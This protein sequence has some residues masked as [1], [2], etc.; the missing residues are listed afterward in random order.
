MKRRAKTA[1]RG[2]AARPLPSRF[3]GPKESPGFL[4]W[5]VS[6]AWQRRQRAALQ[7]LGLTHSQFVILATV[8]W[9]GAGETLTQARIAEISGID[10][11]TTSQV[12]RTLEVAALLERRDHPRDP[13]AKAIAVTPAGREK[14]RK[15]LPI[16]EAV[17][18][19]FFAPLATDVARL[20]KMFD[21]LVREAK[22]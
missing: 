7:P 17:D 12:V 19:A 3:G 18:A 20:V 11:M 2:K 22:G 9:F 8:T 15:A 13:R 10:P 1:P 6:N 5:K 4:L 21:A 14:A 16:V